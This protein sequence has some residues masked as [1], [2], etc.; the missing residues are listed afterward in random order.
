MTMNKLPMSFPP[1]H[2]EDLLEAFALGTLEEWERDEVEAHLDVCPDCSSLLAGFEEPLL[3]VAGVAPQVEPPTGLRSRVMEAVD[4]LPAVFVPQDS[5]EASSPAA[6]ESAFRFTFSSF[7]M[8]LAATLVIGLLT[9][10]L[11][12]N[13]VTT[14]RLN[15][16]EQERLET[17][18]RL[19][20]LERGHASANAGIAQLAVENHETDSALKQVMETSYLMA[21][22]FT[23]PLLLQPT[24]GGS[25][26]EGVL[27]VTNDGKKAILMLAN[28]E[29]PQ[30]SQAYQVWLSRNGQQV[31]VGRIMVDSSGWGTMALNPPESLYGFD[32]M[33]LTMDDP[34]TTIGGGSEMILQT[35]IIS[36]ADR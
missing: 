36:P 17:N 5:K 4:D 23:Q 31:P 22:P 11:I 12:M 24:E 9:A 7:A 32:W 14:T 18:A 28:M 25:D 21:R 1:E 8:P 10:S 3:L 26:S 33:N 34:D 27:L 6:S 30:S 2:P 29:Q 19:E 35:R 20:G 16:L 13:V 15:S